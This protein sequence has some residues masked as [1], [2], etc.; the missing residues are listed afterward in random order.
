MMPKQE[1]ADMPLWC[2]PTSHQLLRV[3]AALR[4][5]KLCETV[6]RLV[7]QQAQVLG[8]TLPEAVQR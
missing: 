4:G 8:V 3:I 5:E 7:R 2:R 1:K 6:E